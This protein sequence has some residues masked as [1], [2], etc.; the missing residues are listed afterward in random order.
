MYVMTKR[1]LA[2][3]T[4]LKGMGAAIALPFLDAMLPAGT[5][6][7]K[8]LPAKKRLIAMEMVHG[9]AGSTAFGAKQHLWAP[10][11][12]GSAFDL[13]PSALAPLEPYRD[14]LTIVSNCDVNN[15]EAF[16][17]PEIGGDHF[18]SAAVFL[19]QS[20][21]QADPGLRHPRRV[22]R[23]TSWSPRRSATRRR[24]RRCSCASRTSIRPAAASTATPAPTPTRSA[25]ARRPSRCR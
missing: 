17:A 2:R 1:H 13:T 7:A 21:P 12:V 9:A 19:T 3:R 5:A 14:Y 20:H 15:A 25:G 8:A 23:S 24:S 10:A 6:L 4:M 22:R 11:A 18:R 16:T